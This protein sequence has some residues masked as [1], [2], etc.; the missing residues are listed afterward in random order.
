[1]VQINSA[2]SYTYIAYTHGI[3]QNRESRHDLPCNDF[4]L[5]C[6][7]ILT[8][9]QHLS[10]EIWART[11]EEIFLVVKAAI[12]VP[13]YCIGIVNS[14]SH[15]SK[16]LG[17]PWIRSGLTLT[18][19][20]IV[21]LSIWNTVM[22]YM[23]A[24]NNALAITLQLSVLSYLLSLFSIWPA[25]HLQTDLINLQTPG[26][27]SSMCNK[28]STWVTIPQQNF[29]TTCLDCRCNGLVLSSESIIESSDNEGGY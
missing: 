23:I 25:I 22:K 2:L 26:Y 21:G 7:W 15:P 11:L 17:T 24:I 8:V 10:W 19:R 18:E 12:T 3:F 1:M 13:E 27:V 9:T 28:Y 6:C 20:S 16:W 5:I 29:A 14:C 4:I